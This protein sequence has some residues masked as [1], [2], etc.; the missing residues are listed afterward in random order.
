[1]KASSEITLHV[2]TLPFLVIISDVHYRYKRRSF[3]KIILSTPFS[4]S[5][6]TG[7]ELGNIYDYI[8]DNAD[9]L[10]V[11]ISG[12]DSSVYKKAQKMLKDW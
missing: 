12:S 4:N 9:A 8:E 11:T 7:E 10:E 2:E 1:M 6:I 3:R 5:E